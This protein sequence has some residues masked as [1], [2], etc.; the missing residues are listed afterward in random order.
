MRGVFISISIGKNLMIKMHWHHVMSYAKY[1]K[2]FELSKVETF[3]LFIVPHCFDISMHKSFSIV[4]K[5]HMVYENRRL[6]YHVQK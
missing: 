1:I 6:T 4:H 2:T 3:L 5:L